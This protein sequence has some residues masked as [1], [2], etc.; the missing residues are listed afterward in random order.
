MSDFSSMTGF[1]SWDQYTTPL[2]APTD[3][4][5]FF[6]TGVTSSQQVR[7]VDSAPLQAVITATLGIPSSARRAADLDWPAR[8]VSVAQTIGQLMT[9]HMSTSPSVT[10]SVLR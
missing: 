8:F 7:T 10:I 9:I 3:Q 2:S 4:A 1:G 5:R 6:G